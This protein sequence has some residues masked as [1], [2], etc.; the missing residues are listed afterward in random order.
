VAPWPVSMVPDKT[1]LPEPQMFPWTVKG[2]PG[3]VVVAMPT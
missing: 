3:S 2:Y 1:M